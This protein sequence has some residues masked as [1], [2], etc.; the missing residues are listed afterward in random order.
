MAPGVMTAA[1]TAAIAACGQVR[2][3]AARA[4]VIANNARGAPT[5]KL[6]K[7]RKKD[8]EEECSHA[9]VLMLCVLEAWLCR[10]RYGGWWTIDSESAC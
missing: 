7:A 9:L 5:M 2:L 6:N 8:S 3:A 4:V 10:G 1:A